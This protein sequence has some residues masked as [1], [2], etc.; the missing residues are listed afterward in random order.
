MACRAPGTAPDDG[1]SN[2]GHLP[3]DETGEASAWGSIEPL[4]YGCYRLHADNR[5]TTIQVDMLQSFE[6]DKL[7]T[8]SFSALMRTGWVVEGTFGGWSGHRFDLHIKPPVS[9]SFDTMDDVH[10]EVAN[11]E[12]SSKLV[13]DIVDGACEI[14]KEIFPAALEGL[15]KLQNGFSLW[16]QS[17]TAYTALCQ[18][19]IDS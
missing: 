2:P 7:A 19:G 10:D 9:R 5:D 6:T 8:V 17:A 16:P 3:S 1:K 12:L 13:K 18:G 14:G 15:E 11:I 4:K